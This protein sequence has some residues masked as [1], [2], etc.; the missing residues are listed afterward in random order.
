MFIT[1][2]G[3]EGSGKSTQIRLLHE[4]LLA[5]GRQVVLTRE[6]G[7][8]PVADRIRAVLLDAA[9]RE[10]A[11]MTELMLY[12]AARAQHL[13]EVVRP[14]LQAGKIVLCDRFSDATRAYQAFGRG[15]NRE[16]VEL[17]NR[18]ACGDLAPDLTVLLDCDTKTGLGRARSRIE[19]NSTGPRE[20]RFE[21][22]SLSFHQRVR[23]GYLKLAADEPERFVVVGADG[24]PQEIAGKILGQV[25]P[26]LEQG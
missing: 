11:P 7:G 14:A 8:C 1:F 16:T 4:A 19:A 12:A 9:N 24:T 21:L 13:T 22:E 17:L 20:E 5:D 3:I 10:M 15:L 23:D 25:I 2:E 6:P 18:L 26:R